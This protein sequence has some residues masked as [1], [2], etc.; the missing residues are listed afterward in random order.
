[1]KIVVCAK[2]DLAGC[3]ALN[4]LLTGL[5]DRHEVFVVLSDY[6]LD[7]EC[8]NA[9]AASLVAHERSMVLEHILPWLEARFP[10]GNAA[11]CQ[12]YLG[13]QQRHNIPMEQWGPMK[14]AQSRQR[15]RELAPDVIISCRYDYVIPEEVIDIPRLGTYGMHP[16]ALPD[17]QGLCSPFRAMEHGHARSGCTLFHLDAGLDTG[18]IV[19]IGWWPIAYGRSLLWNFVHTYF[20]G[21][22]TLLRHLPVLEAGRELSTCVQSAEGRQYFSYPTEA[23][24]RNFTQKVGPL[25][26]A[27]DYYEI[28]SWFLPG[29]LADS[30]L[31]QLRSLVSSLSSSFGSSRACPSAS[32]SAS[33]QGCDRDSELESE[34][35]SE[36]DGANTCIHKN[37]LASA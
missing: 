11:P 2:K 35:K 5:I 9:Y 7:A 27:E 22:D 10:Q 26:V 6:V 28:L 8:S 37:A 25:V 1:M 30:A 4:R 36:L 15:M 14:S 21:I 31:P 32:R 33:R 24:F 17:L 20:A 29:G 23:E 19:E 18:P 12:T 34:L 16:G 13:L 3:V